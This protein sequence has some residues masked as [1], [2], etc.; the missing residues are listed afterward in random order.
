MH[1]R[2]SSEQYS[3]PVWSTAG[4]KK[5]LKKK[6]ARNYHERI[7]ESGNV[8]RQKNFIATECG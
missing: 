4:L 8:T 3:L 2:Y 7:S 6:I 1:I 5:K